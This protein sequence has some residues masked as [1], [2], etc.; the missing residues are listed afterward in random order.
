MIALD[1]IRTDARLPLPARL[2][3]LLD[4]ELGMGNFLDRAVAN[5]P[6][7]NRAFLFAQ[8]PGNPE[9]APEADVVAYSL[10]RLVE[11]R[12][13]YASWYHAQ[14]VGKGDV[15]GVH[16]PEGVD[17]FL[18]FLALTSLGAIAALVNG[19][20]PAEVA[21]EYLG[22]IG[23]LGVV[24][25][26]P[27]LARLRAAGLDTE[28]GAFHT[29]PAELPTTLAADA[30]YPGVFPYAHDDDDLVM[31]CHTSGTTGPPKAASFGH[32]QFF[33]GKRQRLWNFPAAAR[34]RLLTALPQSHSAGISYLMTATLLGLPT[35]VMADTT[36]PAVRAAMR[37]FQPTIVAAFPQTWADLAEIGLE[38]TGAQH[39]H[40]WINTG[41][42][43]HEAHIKEL[44]AHGRRPGLLRSRPGSRFI[45]GLGSSEMGMALFRKVSELGSTD[46]GRCVG[47]PIKVV[48]R[49]VVLDDDGRELGPGRA[50][51]LGVLTPT[52]T[53]G[54]WNNTGATVK[55]SF[56]G[57]W[58]T[59]DVVYR[60]ERGRFIHLDRVPDVIRTADG[61]VYSLPLEE[62]ILVGCAF[63]ADCSVIGVRDP[64]SPDAQAPLAVV[65]LRSGAEEVADLAGSINAVLAAAGLSEVHGVVVAREDADF[66]TGPTGKMLKRQLRERFADHL[67]GITA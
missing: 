45:D 20:M 27:R 10:A 29:D 7:P 36:G 24:A 12:N 62:A 66:P 47:T 9:T 37:R 14:G 38:A 53:P 46:Y 3:L 60:D 15:V 61:P 30:S 31:V 26:A 17:S 43:A 35:L 56:A 50:G 28:R 18:H 59:G 1:N 34:N 65:R 21:V 64:G 58:L 51:R 49:A 52:R 16:V 8:Q 2:K 54:Y 39:V 11:V 13:A 4:R 19:R 32:R 42:A 67:T 22:R 23:V 40:T 41:D 25:D 6:A 44:I 48:R 55:S 57:Y 33:L 5:N 63:V